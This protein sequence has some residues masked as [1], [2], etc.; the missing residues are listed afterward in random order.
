M[1]GKIRTSIAVAVALCFCL[2]ASALAAD[3]PTPQQRTAFNKLL[4]ERSQLTAQLETLDERAAETLKRGGDATSIHAEQIAVQDRLDLI[5]LRLGMM[6]IEYG[7][8]V[9]AVT[10]PGD[11]TSQA[12][13][14]RQLSAFD[15]GRN[16]A[17]QRVGSD[18]ERFL[19]A[20][21]FTAFLH[22]REH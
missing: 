3:R 2:S 15:R 12:V 19:G 7:L 11:N 1:T 13:T 4:Q 9:P 20:L 22:E 8:T 10:R 14:A 5:E 18:Y 17:L 6:A 21:N 16:R